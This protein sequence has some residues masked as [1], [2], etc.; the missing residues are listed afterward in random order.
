MLKR[1]QYVTEYTLQQY[2]GIT[3]HC[4]VKIVRRGK[5]EEDIW[6]VLA[7]GLVVGRDGT[8]EYESFSSS[9]TGQ[10]LCMYRMPLE[11]AWET[12]E[13]WVV[14]LNQNLSGEKQENK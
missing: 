7:D 9:R 12:A 5:L 14:I 4:S 2:S 8:R 10:F 6:A 11:M 3:G 13:K 1:L